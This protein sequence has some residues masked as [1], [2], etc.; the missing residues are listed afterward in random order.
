MKK[1]TAFYG[2]LTAL[3]IILSYVEV[4]IP[5]PIPIVGFKLGL[6]NIISVFLLYKKGFKP[7]FL[8]LICRIVVI[9]ILFGSV[10]GFLFSISG[11]IVSLIFMFILKK[12][13]K[14]SVV[15]VSA[16]GG[17][18]HNIAQIMV[19]AVYLSSRAVFGYAPLLLI[20]GIV[21]GAVIG[22]VATLML[23]ID[24]KN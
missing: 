22:I 24:I 17:V 11:G 10:S 20:V 8:I 7:A 21:S 2:V 19:A 9:N 12:P 15:G 13:D 18:V 23:R 6:S 4:L 14:F 1:N 3:A 5:I 16:V